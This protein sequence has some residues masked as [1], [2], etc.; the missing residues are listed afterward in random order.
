V[1][2]GFHVLDAKN[3]LTIFVIDTCFRH[4]FT[5]TRHSVQLGEEPY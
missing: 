2:R 3:G 4:R 1:Q 5:S